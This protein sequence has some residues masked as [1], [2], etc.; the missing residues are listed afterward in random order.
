[1]TLAD[2]KEMDKETLASPPSLHDGDEKP[3]RTDLEKDEREIGTDLP[4]EVN[5]M[6]DEADVAAEGNNDDVEYPTG[7]RLVFIVIALVLSIFLVR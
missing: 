3:E 4:T 5:S 6:K 7:V 2:D 1:M